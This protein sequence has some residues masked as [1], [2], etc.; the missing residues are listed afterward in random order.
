MGTKGEL[1]PSITDEENESGE[2]YLSSH[3]SLV[4]VRV[5]IRT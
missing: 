2:R 4:S 1:L 3:Y 5:L